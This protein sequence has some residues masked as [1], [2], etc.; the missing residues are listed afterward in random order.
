MDF[1]VKDIIKGKAYVLGNDIDTDQIIPAQHLVYSLSDPKEQ[2][3][4]GR[5]ALSSVPDAGAGL[6][7]GGIRFVEEG[8][9]RSEYN[10][11]IAGKNFGCGSSR[12]HAPVALNIAGVEAVAAESYARI[13]YRNV[14]DGGF[15]IPFETGGHLYK[16]IKTGD[17]IEI[18]VKKGLL[19]NR[20][21]GKEYKLQPLG[22]V[23]DILKAGNIF[24]YARQA[25][26]LRK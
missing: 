6:P 24:A 18:D 19:K 22:D 17:E 3:M 2:V 25:G 7:K 13:F 16:E 9:D 5:F 15:F 1:Q 10:I 8:K 4:Y 14:V 12:E 26:M 21:Q 23:K 20:T 11:L